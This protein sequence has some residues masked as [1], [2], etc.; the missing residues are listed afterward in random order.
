MLEDGG[1]PQK[2]TEQ[3]SCLSD[4]ANSV[5]NVVTALGLQGE[6]LAPRFCSGFSHPKQNIKAVKG[7]Q[8]ITALHSSHPVLDLSIRPLQGLC[9]WQW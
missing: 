1:L 4:P 8:I 9:T 5:R 2:C 3:L 6:H 7:H